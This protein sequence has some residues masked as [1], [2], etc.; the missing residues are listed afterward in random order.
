MPGFVDTDD[1]DVQQVQMAL[2]LLGESIQAMWMLE[3]GVRE[4]LIGLGSLT[5]SLLAAYA[6][7]ERPQRIEAFLRAFREE[8]A[9][10]CVA[11]DRLRR[12]QTRMK[13]TH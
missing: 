10:D 11:A 1:L 5:A 13:P 9:Q 7:D 2:G 4:T 8:I 6:E 3:I 12:S